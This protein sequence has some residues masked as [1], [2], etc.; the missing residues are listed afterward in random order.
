MGCFVFDVLCV[1]VSISFFLG[2]LGSLIRPK[3]V[4]SVQYCKA[5][6]NF[7]H[8]EFRDY[9]AYTGPPTS[10]I[11]PQN[12]RNARSFVLFFQSEFQA[13]DVF[14]SVSYAG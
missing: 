13:N 10:V 7:V 11:Y 8:R 12:V 2:V 4:A 6:H 5:T 9:T 14:V 3:V 1:C